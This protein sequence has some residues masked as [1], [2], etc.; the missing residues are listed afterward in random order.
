MATSILLPIYNTGNKSIAATFKQ[1]TDYFNNPK[2]TEDFKYISSFG[3]APE[4]ADKEFWLMQKKYYQ[5]TGNRTPK[6]KGR[7]E[8]LA[9]QIRQSFRPGEITPEKAN[10]IGYELA[11]RFTKGKHPFIVATHTDKA[12]IHNHIIFSAVE[13]SA[14]RK[15]NNFLQ[16]DMAVRKISDVL[17]MENGLSVIE[18]PAEDKSKNYGKWLKDSNK[19]KKTPSFQNELR[20]QIDEILARHPASFEDFLKEMQD[21]GWEVKLGKQ[22]SFRSKKQS[23]FCSKKQERFTRLRNLG[24]GYTEQD[25]RERIAQSQSFTFESEKDAKEESKETFSSSSQSKEEELYATLH[26]LESRKKKKNLNRENQSFQLLIDLGELP[27]T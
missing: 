13:L 26:S 1:T 25:I 3:C 27:P 17:C 2:K 15:F 21:A 19:K 14:E 23:S 9:Y 11:M 10:Q 18:H 6:G 24:T 22:I 4:T 16:S 12:H 20:T 5:I 7:R 8:V